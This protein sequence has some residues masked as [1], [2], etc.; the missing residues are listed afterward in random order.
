MDDAPENVIPLPKSQLHWED[1]TND[2]QWFEDLDAALAP[3]Q[4]ALFSVRV[5]EGVEDD[6]P[7]AA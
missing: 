1:S 5:L 3:E 7:P 4:R 2:A 6:R